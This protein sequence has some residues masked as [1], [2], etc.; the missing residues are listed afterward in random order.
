MLRC[1]LW[2]NEAGCCCLVRGAGANARCEALHLDEMR[3]LDGISA[4]FIML[5]VR[6]AYRYAIQPLFSLLFYNIYV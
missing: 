4:C 3:R 2:R 5:Q 1:V 6:I